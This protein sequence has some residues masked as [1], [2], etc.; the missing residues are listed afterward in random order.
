[1]ASAKDRHAEAE[2]ERLHH[3][4]VAEHEGAPTWSASRTGTS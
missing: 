2:A 1:M 3:A 4:V